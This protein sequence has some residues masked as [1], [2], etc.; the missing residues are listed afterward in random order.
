MLIFKITPDFHTVLWI[1][2]IVSIINLHSL[3]IFY[4]SYYNYHG[5]IKRRLRSGEAFRVEIRSEYNKI[6]PVM[7]IYFA[8]RAFPIREYRFDEYFMI[9]NELGVKITDNRD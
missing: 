7:L 1:N 9:L 2:R 6:S 8:D 3:I 4:M 5:M